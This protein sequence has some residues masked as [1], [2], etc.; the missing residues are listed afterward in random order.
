MNRPDHI[1]IA[2]RRMTPQRAT[3]IAFV[4][5]VHVAAIYALL[6]ALVPQLRIPMHTGPIIIVKTEPSHERAA[7]A[8]PLRDLT[9]PEGPI[10]QPPKFDVGRDEGSRTI[11]TTSGLLGGDGTGVSQTL[12]GIADTHTTPPYPMSS[13]RLGEQ[14][15]V[16]LLLMV[17][18]DGT[19]L[20]ATVEHSS[21]SFVLDQAAVDWVR[22]HWRYHPL[23]RNGEA[24]SATTE[25]DIRFDIRNAR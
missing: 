10:V 11:T 12:R 2:K 1:G 6:A 15:T 23:V 19:V 18:A 13:L 24:A 8:P 9:R 25:T 21:G 20:T 17:S 3:S 22:K 14:G 16:R 5:A 7:K 4:I